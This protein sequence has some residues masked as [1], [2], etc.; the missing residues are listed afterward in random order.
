MDRHIVPSPLIHQSCRIAVSVPLI[1][2]PLSRP[3]RIHHR[4]KIGSKQGFALA[5]ELFDHLIGHA[6]VHHARITL[7]QGAHSAAHV[8]EACS[9]NF[10]H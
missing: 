5:Q 6:E 8:L 1:G 4:S 3:A 10:A 7:F 2:L 9:A